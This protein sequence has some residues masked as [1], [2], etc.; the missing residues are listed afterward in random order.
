MTTR[1]AIVAIIIGALLI[2]VGW[3]AYQSTRGGVVA[4][5]FVGASV[6]APSSARPIA[7]E[8][9]VL[10]PG[11]MAVSVEGVGTVLAKD[12]VE[13]TSQTSSLVT[14]IEFSDGD[15]VR[16]GDVL[17][18]LDG[19]EAAAALAEA[20]AE[21]A[22]ARSQYTRSRELASSH[23]LAQADFER[24]EANVRAQ[25]A[26][27][28]AAR[29][30]VAHTVL[31]AP[32]SGRV[33][34]RRVSVGSLVA[35]GAVITTLD[36]VSS[37]KL[38]FSV[39]EAIYPLL[40]PGVVVTGTTLVY[41]GAVFEGAILTVDPRIEAATRSVQIRAQFANADGRLAPGMFLT[42][43]LR[44][45]VRNVLIAP[46]RALVPE[47]GRQYV[48]L[49]DDGIARR[50][51]VQIGQRAAAMVEIVS[52]AAPGDRIVVDGAHKLREGLAVAE[53][54]RSGVS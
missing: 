41:P 27:V 29:A 23:A 42:A 35:P 12:A 3:S 52:G 38:D 15:R 10:G 36:D 6:S 2:A 46:E 28:A 37:V 13:I 25:E 53:T 24:L 11:Q 21:L 30:R 22:V 45:N 48:F 39:P 26:R 47:Q 5:S 14:H 4:A 51:E 19:E 20:E 1:H 54:E 18:R 7:V 17:A 9:V 43:S 31:R 33:G 49:I 34:L 50:V 40:L 32:F 16:K 8:T 44:L